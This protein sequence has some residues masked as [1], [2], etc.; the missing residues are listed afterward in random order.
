M[1]LSALT[2]FASSPGLFDLPRQVR[3]DSWPL[4][5]GDAVDAGVAKRAVL[6][7]QVVAQH[8]VE[9]GADPFDGAAARLVH[10]MRAELDGEASQPVEGVRQQQQLCFGVQRRAL[11]AGGNNGADGCGGFTATQLPQYFKRF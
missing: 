10:E 6:H 9:S 1:L 4:G 8:A 7:A 2:F 3:S 11:D 5:R